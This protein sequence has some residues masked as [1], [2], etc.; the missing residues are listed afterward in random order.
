[1]DFK[2]LTPAE[3]QSLLKF[4]AYVSLLAANGD[5]KFDKA[6]KLAALNIE[7]IKSYASHPLLAAFF[8][9]VNEKFEATLTALAQSLPMERGARNTA[10]RKELQGLEKILLKLDEEYAV[11]MHK[12][13]ASL[14]DHVSHAHNNVLVDFL[15]PFPLK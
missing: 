9:E 8:K 5:G 7:H 15:F 6:E 4:P 1:M 2:N 3:H 11:A 12:S 13:M 14:K 10:I